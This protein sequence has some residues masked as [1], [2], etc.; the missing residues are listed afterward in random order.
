MVCMAT[1]VKIL[2]LGVVSWVPLK[3]GQCVFLQGKR[4]T[5]THLYSIK[6]TSAWL[7][8]GHVVCSCRSVM[9]LKPV[10]HNV[11][12]SNQIIH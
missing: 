11:G 8:N 7:S 12:A 4:A 2:E 1:I 9:Y 3:R 5:N 10:K 6:R